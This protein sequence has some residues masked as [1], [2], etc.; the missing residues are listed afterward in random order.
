MRHRL[1]ELTGLGAALWSAVI[2]GALST[3]G[4]LIWALYI[5]THQMIYGLV[6]GAVLCMS[7]G[8]VLGLFVAK[9]A[10][11]GA[12]GELVIGLVVSGG[13]YAL[14]GLLGMAAMFVSWMALWLL[15]SFFL[16]WLHRSPESCG[17][18]AVRGVLAAVLS[19]LTFYVISGIWLDPDPA[20]PNYAYHLVAWTFA[21]LPGFVALLLTRK[22]EAEGL[23]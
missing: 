16:R 12:L 9:K 8:F 18:T 10:F 19:G 7:L 3:L 17:F 15:T 20:G 13:F 1:S 4:D 22:K 14:Y 5:P 11:Q 23:G 6:H 21:F 2:L